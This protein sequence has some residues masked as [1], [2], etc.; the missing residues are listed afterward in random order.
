MEFP[1]KSE[2]HPRH[3]TVEIVSPLCNRYSDD[4]EQCLY[5]EGRLHFAL[6]VR[7]GDRISAAARNPHYIDHLEALMEL[8]SLAVARKGLSPPLFHVFTQTF[9]PCPSQDSALF[10]EFPSWPMEN[11]QVWM[12]GS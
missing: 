1:C 6:H 10:D 8:I 9:M 5:D 2:P 11:D 4:P 3:L 12:L 7:L